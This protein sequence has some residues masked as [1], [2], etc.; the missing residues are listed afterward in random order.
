M[1]AQDDEPRSPGRSRGRGGRPRAAWFPLPSVRGSDAGRFGSV[2]RGRR[3][4]DPPG[5]VE[6]LLALKP[7]DVDRGLEGLPGGLRG[8]A[9]LGSRRAG[10]VRG[11]ARGCS[12]TRARGGS[13]GRSRPRRHP[14]ASRAASPRARRV[15]SW[16]M[17]ASRHG[18]RGRVHGVQGR[19]GVGVGD[20]RNGPS[21]RLFG[22]RRRHP[23]PPAGSCTRRLRDELNR[24]ADTRHLP[25]RR[26]PGVR[27]SRHPRR[28]CRRAT[29]R[30]MN[31]GSGT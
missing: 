17:C 28:A 19:L 12:G 10:A 15:E 26:D 16:T 21:S 29:D 4:R 23:T 22:P 14:S 11:T 13:R 25:A 8:D 1:I 2:R 30:D 3:R 27:A 18:R 5:L 31:D 6:S 24:G 7:S 9:C 20:G